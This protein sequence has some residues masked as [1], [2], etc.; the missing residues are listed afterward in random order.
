M[1]N[2]ESGSNNFCKKC[3]FQL[4][5]SSF[6]IKE[7]VLGERRRKLF[8]YRFPCRLAVVIAGVG[9]WWSRDSA[10][11]PGV[12]PTE[13]ERSRLFRTENC[14]WWYSGEVDKEESPSSD[15][16]KEK[17]MVRFEDENN[18]LKV[19]LLSTLPSGES[20][21]RRSMC[22]PCPI[23]AFHIENKKIVCNAC[24][25]EWNLETLRDQWG[26]LNY[27]RVIPI[28]LREIASKWMRKWLFNG[29]R[30]Y[31]D[32][33]KFQSSKFQ[34]KSKWQRGKFI[35]NTR[36]LEL[37]DIELWYLDFV[38]HVEVTRCDLRR[39]FYQ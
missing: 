24:G 13:S 19:P 26:C 28:R 17:K 21:H 31:K 2:K 15:V 39:H 18:G 5:G 35:L 4:S 1:S 27:R 25:T 8:G 38:A 36:S 16:V 29:N 6:Q 33:V 20:H 37:F 3:G 14:P 12:S 34:M 23:H 11:A 30:E 22:E 9:Y 7:K 32:N 10:A